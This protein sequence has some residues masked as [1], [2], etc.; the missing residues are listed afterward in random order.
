[1]VSIGCLERNAHTP[2]EK[3]LISSVPLTYKFAFKI[4]ETL[5]KI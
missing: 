1:M 5:S 2:E 3:V 4:I